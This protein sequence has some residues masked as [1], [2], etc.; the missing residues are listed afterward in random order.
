MTGSGFRKTRKHPA[1]FIRFIS[2]MET[3]IV[4][5]LKADAFEIMVPL[6]DAEIDELERFL[7]SDFTSDETLM[8]DG[9]DGY[10]TAIAVGPTT[11]RPSEWL[12]GIWGSTPGD[13]PAFETSEQA[14][15]I[16]ELIMRHYNG[17][18]WSLQNSPDEF[19]PLIGTMTYAGDAH[20]YPDAEGWAM[21]FMQGVALAHP[22]WEP[23]LDDAQGEHWLRPLHLLGAE[24][25]SADDEALTRLPAQ[26]ETL[27]AQI[28]SSI[29][30][31]YRF[32]LPYRDAVHER[33]LATTIRR[34]SPKIGRN[35]PCPCGSGKKF[36][37]CC[38]AAS[39]LH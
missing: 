24:E 37:K 21:G 31:I 16:F 3:L 27:A 6:A 14:Q 36:K 11:L 33:Q 13:A 30:A 29:A 28:P 35:D 32:W 17:I 15:R 25:V 10:L 4:N 26:R 34:N 19:Q 5:K 12:P 1:R 8:L 23:L 18:I 7:M 22:H 2:F 38:D 20:E 39:I 9:L